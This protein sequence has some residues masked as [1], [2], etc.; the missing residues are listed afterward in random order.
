MIFILLK[1]AQEA[2]FLKDNDAI[3]AQRR[4]SSENPAFNRPGVPGLLDAVLD[5]QTSNNYVNAILVQLKPGTWTGGRHPDRALE[6]AR[7]L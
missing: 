4:R 6:T 3:L 2:Q 1:D 5:S 7:G